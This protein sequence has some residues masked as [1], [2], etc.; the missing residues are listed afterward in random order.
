MYSSNVADNV[1]QATT[2]LLHPHTPPTSYPYLT[3]RIM[4]IMIIRMI[5][6]FFITVLVMY[7]EKKVY[8]NSLLQL[9]EDRIAGLPFPQDHS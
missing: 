4:M 8:I 6:V 2:T 9:L 1:N 7:K 5:G 3:S